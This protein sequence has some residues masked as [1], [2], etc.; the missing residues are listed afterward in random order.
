M[1]ERGITQPTTPSTEDFSR[2]EGIYLSVIW[3]EYFNI[4]FEILQTLWVNQD[5]I[6]KQ[7]SP[8]DRSG[9]CLGDTIK[10]TNDAHEA[11]SN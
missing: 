5:S 2:S 11:F 7:D 10:V 3:G 9:E 1:G 6:R 8:L 4:F